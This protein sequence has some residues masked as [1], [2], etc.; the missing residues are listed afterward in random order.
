MLS[1]W[2]GTSRYVYNKTIEYLRQPNT[3]A[4][5]K[6]IK[7]GIIQNL[8]E[9][10]KE[11]PYQIKSIAIRDACNAVKQSKIMFKKTGKIHKAKFRSKKNG[12]YNIYIPKASVNS[13]G[14]YPRL[15]GT[16]NLREKVGDVEY[17]CRVTL[18]NGRYFLNIPQKRAIKIPD[19]QRKS[20]VALDPGVRTFQT[21]FSETSAIKVGQSDFARI[22]RLCYKLDKLYS[23]RSKDFTNR[24]NRKL[25]SI[26]W[27]IKD[28]I[29]EIHHK[30]ALFLVKSYENILIP[31]FETSNMVTKL[32]SK[33]ARAMLGWSHYRFKMILKNKA[34]EYSCN[35]I[36]VNESYTSKTCGSCGK[37]NN[38]GSR[39]ILK[40]SC[41]ISI[42]RD[43]NGARNIF[44][45]NVLATKDS[46]MLL[47]QGQNMNLC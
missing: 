10:S 21:L 4:D 8:P 13:D 31:S 43:Y 36:E 1:K 45:K 16:V 20:V 42:D 41:G 17:D 39:S 12:D 33:V 18:E 37:I 23:K 15:M 14:F 26:R 27:K 32:N 22:Y 29:S 19:N 40:C 46:S 6:Y 44:L 24:Y 5:W 47:T 35:V 28:L 34:E 2:F 30:L 7:T 11:V 25:K 9:W 38:V 3:K